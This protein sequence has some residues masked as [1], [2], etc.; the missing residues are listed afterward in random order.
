MNNETQKTNN[1][2]LADAKAE[3]G[4]Q[5]NEWNTWAQWKAQ[6]RTVR[7]GE[8]G[9]R[10]Y[11]YSKDPELNEHYEIQK[12]FVGKS[13]SVFNLEQTEAE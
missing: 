12:S 8:K 2:I 9:T 1:Q 5:S 7:H 4:Y 10:I 11:V 3:K 6:G 13:F